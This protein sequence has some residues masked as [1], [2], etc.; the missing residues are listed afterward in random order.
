M[1]FLYSEVSNIHA[2]HFYYF[3][4]FLPTNMA[5]LETTH[6]FILGKNSAYMVIG[7]KYFQT[8]WTIFCFKALFGQIHVFFKL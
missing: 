4:E 8:F 5:L 6:L 2:A 7:D 1:A 3:L